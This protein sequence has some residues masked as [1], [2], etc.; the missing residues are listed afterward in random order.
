MKPAE[1]L[2]ALVALMAAAFAAEGKLILC[3]LGLFF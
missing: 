1:I 2:L 3:F